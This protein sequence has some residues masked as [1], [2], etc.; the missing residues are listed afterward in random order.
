MKRQVYNPYLPLS[1]YIPDGEPHVFDER[2]YIFGSHDKEGGY[3]FCMDDYVTYSAPVYDLTD[4]KYE[5]VIYKASQDPKFGKIF[6]N[7]KIRDSRGTKEDESKC[8]RYMY[9]PDVVK[10]NDGKYYLFYCMGGDYGYGG[11]AGPVSVAVSNN[12]SGP[13][14][15]H[16]HVKNSDGS[17]M[18]KYICF[19]PAV[20]ND[21]GV[22]RLYYGTQYSYEEEPDFYQNERYI[23]EEINMFGRIKEEI[24]SYKDSIMGPVMLVLEDDMITV[25]EEPHHIIPYRVKGTS[26]EQHPF[27]EGASIRKVNNK[28]YFVYSSWL[29]H[30]LCYAVSDYPDRDFVYGGTIVSNGDVGYDGRTTNNR[31]N[32]TGTTHGGIEKI[33]NDWYVFFHRLTHKSDYSRQSCAEKIVINP[34]GSINQVEVTSCGLNNG[35]LSGKGTYPAAIACNITQGQMPHGSNTIYGIEFPHVTNKDDERFIAEIENGTLL[36]YKYFNLSETSSFIIKVRF[37]NK[38]NKVV[39][40]V[41]LRQDE[42]CADEEKR[43]TDFSR[44]KKI[45]EDD[46][47]CIEIRKKLPEGNNNELILCNLINDQDTVGIIRLDK[48]SE[49]LQWDEYSLNVNHVNVN[50]IKTPLYFIYHGNKK[51]QFKEFILE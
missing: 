39:Y 48:C 10:G 5:G 25:K 49:G 40:N 33:G 6:E 7:G 22:I 18:M 41:P 34:D 3:T 21:N 23:Q 36:G 20:I 37:E 2:V 26:F 30:E 9:A 4:W 19:D 17:L 16:G 29:N 42:R 8:L 35:P 1:E 47:P 24:L 28:Y 46:I 31:L 27:F 50:D 13:Y 12:P 45:Y 43:V 11:Y 32:M 14:E 15:F 44:S 38:D 51:I